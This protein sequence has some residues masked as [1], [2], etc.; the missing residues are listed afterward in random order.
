MTGCRT[1]SADLADS[2]GTSPVRTGED[3]ESESE[4]ES[5]GEGESESEGE[6]ESEPDR[7]LALGGSCVVVRRCS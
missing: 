5:E 2:I 7:E 6:G 1:P 4:S 3:A